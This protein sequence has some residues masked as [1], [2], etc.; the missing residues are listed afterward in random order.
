MVLPE[1][2]RRPSRQRAVSSIFQSDRGRGVALLARAP[3]RTHCLELLLGEQGG[4]L[5][6]RVHTSVAG[7]T[8]SDGDRHVTIQTD[9]VI[10]HF[11]QFTL[12]TERLHLLR[13]GEPVS[14][15]PQVFSLLVF[16]IENRERVVSKDDLIDAVWQGRIVSDAT[17]SSR[18]NLA[19]RAVGDGGKTQVIIRTFPRRGFRFI[20]EVEETEP[21]YLTAGPAPPD[22]EVRL[23]APA[24]PRDTE[25]PRSLCSR[26][27][28]SVVIQTLMS[29][30]M[31]W[32]RTSWARWPASV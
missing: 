31:A 11:D 18:I 20:A 28:T 14:L 3:E 16:L 12:D 13:G 22:D 4:E 30:P 21:T 25:N 1:S 8:G 26:S 29:L 27:K 17:I 5:G 6:E 19:R 32:P 2:A 24:E 9:T 10:Y 7:Q 15:E 23:A